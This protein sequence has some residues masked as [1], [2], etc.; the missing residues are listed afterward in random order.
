[1]REIPD[2]RDGCR[3]TPRIDRYFTF[4]VVGRQLA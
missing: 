2:R 4:N 3:L 1:V